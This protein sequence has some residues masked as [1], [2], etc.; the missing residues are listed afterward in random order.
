MHYSSVLCK[1]ISECD[2][3]YIRNKTCVS[4]Q[5]HCKNGIPCNKLTGRCDNGC[6][7][8]WS[9]I[10]CDGVYAAQLIGFINIIFLH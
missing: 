9:G 5:G 8:Y 2:G 10:F 4:C 7:N 1:Y 3:G 6:Q